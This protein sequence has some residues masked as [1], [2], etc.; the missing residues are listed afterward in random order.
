MQDELLKSKD[1]NNCLNLLKCVA[2]VGVVF[3]HVAFPGFWGGIIKGLFYFA[4]PLF[5]MISG[6]YAY[7]C[8]CER[9]KKR[10]MKIVKKM[11]FAIIFLLFFEILLHAYNSTLVMWL[12]DFLSWKT[13]VKMIVFCTIDWAIPLWYLIAMAETYLVWLYVVKKRQKKE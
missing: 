13:F 11:L 5:Y 1:R 12:D 7:G 4:V 10:L 2:C 8:T 3:I 9:I 6:Y